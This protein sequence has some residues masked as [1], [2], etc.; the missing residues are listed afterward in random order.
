MAVAALTIC[1]P[2]TLGADL[3]MEKKGC[4]LRVEADLAP[5]GWSTASSGSGFLDKEKSLL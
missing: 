2:F 5:A 1:V 4:I 3:C